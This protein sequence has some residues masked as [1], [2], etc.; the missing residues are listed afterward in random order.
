MIQPTKKEF[1]LKRCQRSQK[2]TSKFWWVYFLVIIEI[3]AIKSR[4]VI[5][6][7]QF[8]FLSQNVEK[9]VNPAYKERTQ[10]RT[11]PKISKIHI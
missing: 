5:S 9:R 4:T 2:F 3:F 11:M 6:E 7:T 10:F 8:L 1:N